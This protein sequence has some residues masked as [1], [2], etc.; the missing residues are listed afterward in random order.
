VEQK[1][2]NALTGV[3]IDNLIEA[4]KKVMK[5]GTPTIMIQK[6]QHWREGKKPLRGYN[7]TSPTIRA[8]MGDNMPMIIKKHET[9]NRS[10]AYI[11][12]TQ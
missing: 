6:H 4:E 1:H 5:I 3:Q 2:S 11:S 7:D 8:N 10:R 9:R 12:Q